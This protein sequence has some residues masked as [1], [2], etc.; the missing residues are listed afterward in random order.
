MASKN[1]P[2]VWETFLRRPSDIREGLEIPLVIRDLKP[3]RK[4]YALRHVLAV[5]S[6]KAEEIAKMD[7]LRVRTVVGVQL[8]GPWG[9]K[10]LKELPI[11]LPGKPYQDF[12]LALRAWGKEEKL[13]R[14]R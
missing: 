7:E 10:I 5:V 12:F 14:E 3:G 9:I 11:E 13:D 1:E 2:R 8:P 4:K 6:R